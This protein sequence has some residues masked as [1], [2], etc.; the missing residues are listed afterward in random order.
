MSLD[1]H[2]H[3]PPGRLVLVRHGETAWSRSGRHTGRTDIGLTPEGERQ[4]AALRP[5]LRQFRFALVATS[6]RLRAIRTADLAGLRAAP[7]GPGPAQAQ[8]AEDDGATPPPL[9]VAAREVWPE[10]A[11]WDYGDLEGLTTTRIREDQ[12]GWTI[13]TG[14][15][16]GGES[17]ARV[18]A[19]ADAAL[20]RALPA[21]RDGDVAL[22][23]HGHLTR[24]LIARWL[25]LG[26]ASGAWFLVEPAGVSILRHER[27]TR[28]LGALNLRPVTPGDTETAPAV[29]AA[30][31]TS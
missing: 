11:E 12:P 7:V 19:R 8:R 26:P 6:P 31:Q 13:W 5:V 21:L 25:G 28:V 3:P 18:A 2:D 24:V 30:A 14:R 10:L 22:V 4:A 29:T 17:A 16:P 20:A 23:G 9:D 15:V 27:E 1:F